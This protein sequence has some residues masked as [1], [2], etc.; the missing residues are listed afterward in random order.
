MTEK[1]DYFAT[2]CNLS[3]ALGTTLGEEEILNLIVESA[4]DTMNAKAACLF[5]SD[6]EK[7]VFVPVAQQGLSENY[8]HA[9]PLRVTAVVD[10]ILKEGY[11]FARDATTDPRLE[12]HEAKKAEGIASI[13]DVPVM[14]R[15]HAIGV[16]ALYTASPREFSETDIDFLSALAEQGGMA[17]ERARLFERINRNSKLFFNLAS[18]INSSLDIKNI[19]H[20]LTTDLG[21]ALGIKG[22]SIRLLKKDVG[23]LSLVAS[24][25]LS[26]EYLSKEAAADD[27][28]VKEVLSG[29]QV[30]VNDVATD[31]GFQHK[32]ATL[33]EG[34][35]SMLCLPITSGDEV[36]GV[37]GLC[38]AVK[39]DFPE[40][41]IKLASAVGHQGG[42][43]IQ[44]ASQYLMLQEDKKNLEE[45][46]WTH[47]SWF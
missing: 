26:K 40:E 38:S 45:E 22:V 27:R 1:N 37:M 17:I 15:D 18:N 19:L 43:A 33:R 4:I 14:V 9:G 46:I 41:V 30:V 5:L 28:S 23:T 3:K 20:I 42:Q 36:I 47:K 12:N 16:L 2:F 39:N 31:E 34:I 10:E 11:L 44:N 13:L 21:E 6:E 32:D 8:F 25:G 24:H 29:K 7:D 35:A